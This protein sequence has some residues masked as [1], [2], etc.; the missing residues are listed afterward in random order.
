MRDT[1][2]GT[3]VF[4]TLREL[5]VEQSRN[6]FATC[7]QLEPMLAVIRSS[8]NFCSQTTPSGRLEKPSPGRALQCSTIVFT[9]HLI[10]EHFIG[11]NHGPLRQGLNRRPKDRL[12]DGGVGGVLSGQRLFQGP[13][14]RRA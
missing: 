2:T 6:Y 9:I 5:E 7:L 14:L 3:S 1:L 4:I 8:A 13:A 10:C 12:P 11:P